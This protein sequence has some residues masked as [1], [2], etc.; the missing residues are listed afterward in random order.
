MNSTIPFEIND[1]N[2][3]E[4]VKLLVTDSK[5][6]VKGTNLQN[7]PSKGNGNRIRKCFLPPPGWILVGADLSSIEPRIMA[8]ILYAEYGDN[9]M[10]GAY[11]KGEDPYI[12]VAQMVFDLPREYCLDGRKDPTGTFEPRKV[13][14]QGLLAVAYRQS[15]KG[16]SKTT[17][18]PL[19]TAERFLDKFNEMYPNFEKM[20]SDIIN[21]M[22]QYGFTDTLFGRKRRFPLYGHYNQKAEQ[23]EQKLINLY[24]ERKKLL[25]NDKLSKQ[26]QERLNEVQA[27]INELRYFRA[28]C[29]KMERESFNS[30]IQGTGADILKQNGN[31]MARECRK[32]GWVMPASIHDELIITMPIED[33][34]PK[35]IDLVNDIMTKTVKLSVPLET[36]IVI[37]DRWM[38]EKTPEEYFKTA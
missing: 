29:M 22:K 3:H 27:K 11:L 5:E 34:T 13:A 21:H 15:A 9:S 19:K 6:T 33:C 18:V 4:L 35:A 32:R 12:D 1:Y 28:S 31:R 2:Y 16:F 26:Q 25:S 10:R 24:I 36:D 23:N 8:H 30:K 14:K 17:G 37:M 38:N 20:V 7:I